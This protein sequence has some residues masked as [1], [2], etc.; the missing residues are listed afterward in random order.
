MYTYESIRIG[1]YKHI[2]GI[3][4]CIHMNKE[5]KPVIPKGNQP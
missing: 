2:I 5:I 4:V 3:N 1:I